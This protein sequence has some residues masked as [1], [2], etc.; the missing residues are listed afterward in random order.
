MH[1]TPKEV[2]FHW[3]EGNLS[4]SG[5]SYRLQ[6]SFTCLNVARYNKYLYLTRVSKLNHESL[7]SEHKT[8]NKTNYSG[9]LHN[10]CHKCTTSTFLKY[11]F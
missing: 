9:Q 8:D 2:D 11:F 7:L 10:C 5:P 4:L 3:N 1:H 6:H